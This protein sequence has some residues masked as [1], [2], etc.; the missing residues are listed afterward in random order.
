MQ[1][2][3][4]ILGWVVLLTL[5]FAIVRQLSEMPQPYLLPDSWGTQFATHGWQPPFYKGPLGLEGFQDLA[6]A[7]GNRPSIID[8]AKDPK[9]KSVGGTSDLGLRDR[10]IVD[11]SDPNFKVDAPTEGSG[12]MSP[13]DADLDVRQPYELLKDVIP[14]KKSPG[15]L[16]AKTCYDKDFISQS[17][18]CNSKLNYI[19][20]TNNFPHNRPDNCSAPLTELVD[21]F[22][23]NP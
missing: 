17:D 13:A 10:L 1:D 20:R 15:D 8:V 3:L 9:F 22:Y 11:T 2:S 7:H 14:V 12:T 6:L 23:K 19:Q 5:I 4:K 16:T 21:S 18:L